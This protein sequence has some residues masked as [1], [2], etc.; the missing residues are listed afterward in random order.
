MEKSKKEIV[1]E[2][3]VKNERQLLSYALHLTG[4]INEAK[5]LLQEVALHSLIKAEKYTE[6]GLFVAWA[7]EMMKNQFLN[8]EKSKRRRS[9]VNYDDI[10]AYELPLSV[11][12]SDCSADYGSIK[13]II[14]AL[15]VA[16]SSSFLLAVDGWSYQ[17]ISEKTGLSINDV[18]NY[19]HAA[20]V[21]MRKELSDL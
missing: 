7:R 18:R 15:P 10:P 19:I 11:A 6:N 9:A 17:E 1:S 14:D 3:F 20:R 8:I 13:S 16:Q 5:D 21:K 4:D 12:E 2:E